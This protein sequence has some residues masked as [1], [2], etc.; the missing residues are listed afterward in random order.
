MVNTRPGFFIL[1]KHKTNLFSS[2]TQAL[3]SNNRENALT[4]RLNSLYSVLNLKKPDKMEDKKNQIDK[5]TSSVDTT[6]K[7]TGV[8]RI[9]FYSDNPK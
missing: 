6:P 2:I 5:S 3:T 4:D 7:V 1:Q 8:G 9:F